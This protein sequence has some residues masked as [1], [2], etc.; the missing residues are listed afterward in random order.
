M[1]SEQWRTVS[2]RRYLR[3]MSRPFELQPG[4]AT[5]AI[6]AAQGSSHAEAMT[7]ASAGPVATGAVSIIDAATGLAESTVATADARRASTFLARSEAVGAAAAASVATMV[8][9]DEANAEN[10]GAVTV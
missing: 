10:L 5:A 6:S 4:I 3:S 7:T 9:I 2:S 1:C 8:A